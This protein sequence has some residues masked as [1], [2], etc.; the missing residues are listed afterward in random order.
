MSFHSKLN[1]QKA[2]PA[3]SA[4]SAGGLGATFGVTG[5]GALNFGGGAR[6]GGGIIPVGCGFGA[7]P[8]PWA[9]GVGC[10]AS[11]GCA[12]DGGCGSAALPI[13]RYVAPALALEAG[14][15]WSGILMSAM[16]AD[17]HTQPA[18]VS[19]QSAK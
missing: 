13:V 16:P 5:C 12:L 18:M 17:S 4:S 10:S 19:L 3:V 15:A 8:L 7:D 9:A 11:M 1:C 14:C 2:A 6:I